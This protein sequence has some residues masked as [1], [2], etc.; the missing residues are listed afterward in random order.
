MN[1]MQVNR[2]IEVRA[3]KGPKAVRTARHNVAHW[4]T[5]KVDDYFEQHGAELDGAEA[6]ELYE[7]L[8]AEVE[9]PLLAR[10]LKHTRRNQSKAAKILGLSRGTLRKKLKLHDFLGASR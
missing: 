3:P 7:L 6:G 5:D 9:K 8:L 1:T 10:V 2:G 4:V